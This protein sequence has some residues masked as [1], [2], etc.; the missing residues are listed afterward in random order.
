MHNPQQVIGPL[1]SFS[2]KQGFSALFGSSFFPAFSM[3]LFFQPS[4][5]LRCIGV[6]CARY[7]GCCACNALLRDFCSIR[8]GPYTCTTET[9]GQKLE[10][11]SSQT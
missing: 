7:E 2:Q 5:D 11:V 10:I 9:K 3:V 1:P 8:L 4:G 6:G